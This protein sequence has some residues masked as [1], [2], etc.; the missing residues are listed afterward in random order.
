[1][2]EIIGEH[3]EVI[4]GKIVVIPE[5]LIVTRS[6]GSLNTLVAH[7]IEIS[8]CWVVDTLVNHST[9]ECVPVPVLV[10]I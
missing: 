9:R 5:D 2:A 10:G 8:F 1:M 6:A 4:S 3:L 7:K